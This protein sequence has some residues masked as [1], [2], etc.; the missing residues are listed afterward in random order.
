M[1]AGDGLISVVEIDSETGSF[2]CFNHMSMLPTDSRD[3]LMMKLKSNDMSYE[4][5]SG[6]QMGSEAEGPHSFQTHVSW[7]RHKVRGGVTATQ[8]IYNIR[9]PLPSSA[10]AQH[11]NCNNHRL[12]SDSSSAF[13]Q[14]FL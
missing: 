9:N 4:L 3:C 11:L 7:L 13:L 8:P 5:I 14:I 2:T 6:V 1:I 10:V 12:Y